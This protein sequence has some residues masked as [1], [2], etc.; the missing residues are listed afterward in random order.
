VDFNSSRTTR[1]GSRPASEWQLTLLKVSPRV[2]QPSLHPRS[3]MLSTVTCIFSMSRKFLCRHR[4]LYLG[5]CPDCVSE[6]MSSIVIDTTRT[7]LPYGVAEDVS[8]PATANTALNASRYRIARKQSSMV[9]S[10]ILVW[11]VT[12]NLPSTTISPLTGLNY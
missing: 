11:K 6:F 3:I 1:Q 4:I 9:H 10:Q 5:H 7:D 2:G 12:I 8:C